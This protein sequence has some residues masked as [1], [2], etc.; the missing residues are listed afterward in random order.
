[1]ETASLSSTNSGGGPMTLV[2]AP[3]VESVPLSTVASSSCAIAASQLLSNRPPGQAAPIP[4]IQGDH[5]GSRDSKSS[6]VSSF[7]SILERPENEEEEERIE[8]ELDE[9]ARYIGPV[10]KSLFTPVVAPLV[11]ANSFADALGV[12]P[13]YKQKE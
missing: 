8:A 1:M 11:D 7:S 4:I 5:I 6:V 10:A 12:S 3:G 13:L 9:M 2:A